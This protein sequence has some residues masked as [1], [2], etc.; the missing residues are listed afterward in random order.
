MGG[1]VIGGSVVQCSFR[2]EFDPGSRQLF[3]ERDS[4][5]ALIPSRPYDIIAS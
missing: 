5:L 4:A 2:C 1:G 3:L